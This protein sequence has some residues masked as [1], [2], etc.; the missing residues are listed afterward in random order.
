VAAL[1]ALETAGVTQRQFVVLVFI[2]GETSSSKLASL[3]SMSGKNQQ[4]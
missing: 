3:S 2:G 1:P 4:V